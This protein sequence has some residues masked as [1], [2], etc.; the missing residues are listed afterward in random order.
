M[1]QG[2][3][4]LNFPPPSPQTHK[5]IAPGVCTCRDWHRTFSVA[6][7]CTKRVL[8]L[9][10]MARHASPAMRAMSL[11]FFTS[12]CSYVPQ[13]KRGIQARPLRKRAPEE[14]PISHAVQVQH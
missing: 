3:H 6:D 10:A 7:I 1:V 12:G 2:V 11:T 8:S 5:P 9:G 14:Q 4:T 13:V